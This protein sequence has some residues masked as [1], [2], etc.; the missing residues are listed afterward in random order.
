MRIHRELQAFYEHFLSET[1]PLA[2]RYKLPAS[3]RMLKEIQCV[4]RAFAA[5]LLAGNDNMLE[6]IFARAEASG[7]DQLHHQWLKA[8]GLDPAVW[9]ET[10]RVRFMV[11]ALMQWLARAPAVFSYG[12]PG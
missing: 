9:S 6:V 11:I 3:T 10:A 7:D 5:R 8:N 12:D 1:N 4:F 2:L